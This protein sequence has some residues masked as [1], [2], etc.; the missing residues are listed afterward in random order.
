MTSNTGTKA[1]QAADARHHIHPFTDAA[2]LAAKGARVIVRAEGVWIED[3]EGHRI[4]D[5]MAGLWCV[6]VGYGNR[7]LA[8]AGYKALL[9]LPYYNAFFQTTH[10]H[11]VEL[12]A[13]LASIT[14]P[15]LDRVLF[16]N[17]GSEAN[18]TIIKL[19]RYYWNLQGKPKKKIMIG[20]K[21][22]YHGVTLGAA[23]LSGLTPLHP[24][25]DLPLPGFVHVDAPY[26]Y[27]EG[28]DL[29]PQ[30]FGLKAAR[31]LEAKILEL[32]A[33]NVAAFIGEPI[34]GAG[35]VIIPP[36][37]YW[38]EVQRICAE[39][40][41]L[42]IADEVICGFGRTGKWFGCDS[43]NIKP[44]FMTLAKGLSSGYIPISAVMLGARVGDAI[45]NANEELV[46]GYTYSGHPVA[47]AVALKNIEIL[48]RDKLVEKAGNDI[49]PYLQDGLGSLRDHPLVG[50]VRGM[51]MIGAVELVADKAARKHFVPQLDVGMRCRNH[52]FSND[53]IMRAI[54]DIMV[55][56]PPLT[57]TRAEVDELIRRAR[58]C[59][60]LTAKEISGVI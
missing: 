16:A 32:G 47:C 4:L 17:S 36:D 9:D 30:E 42:L 53:L 14:P 51:G 49:G 21:L 55:V 34:Q 41:I 3:S 22:G 5:G 45:A 52:C 20:R 7:E 43:F 39:H 57:I 19:T 60:D 6:N 31:S 25:W 2:A 18:D 15:G 54:R 35:G 46:H 11:A 10:P 58:R 37:S 27:G 50:E 33:E 1:W 12:S 26:W 59:L 48:E 38:P 28:G 40:D 13:K 56:S 44:D 8:E 29:S 23:S 24:Q